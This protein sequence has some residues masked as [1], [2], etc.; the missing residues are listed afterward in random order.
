MIAL[1]ALLLLAPFARSAPVVGFIEDWPGTSTQGWDGGP[2]H[3]VFSNPGSG[4]VGGVGDGFLLGTMSGPPNFFGARSFGVEYT[5]DWSA[6]GVNALRFSLNDV[7]TT[8]GFEIHFCIG[9]L[10]NFWQYDTGYIAP[11]NQWSSFTVDL[12]D[13]NAFTQIIAADGLGYAWA[14]QHATAI[15]LR[16]DRAPFGQFPDVII[17]DVAIDRFELLAGTV[18]VEDPSPTRRVL[19]LRPPQPNPSRGPVAFAIETA[20]PAAVTMEIV[21]V[22]GRRVRREV[23]PAG[24]VGLRTWLWDGRDQDGRLVAAGGYRV[25][26]VGSSGGVS[27]GLVRLGD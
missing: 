14:L 2:T 10:T 27:R 4:G 1:T 23:L 9:T 19:R 12:S 13:S 11:A 6:A 25:R 5:G 7:G 8:D 26:A 3:I 18:G 16:H 17:G 20:E 21:D 22:L 15:L 24:P